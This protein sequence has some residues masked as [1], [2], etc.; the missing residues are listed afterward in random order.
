M[1]VVSGDGE[2]MI[3]GGKSRMVVETSTRIKS[4]GWIFVCTVTFLFTE[5]D[6][7]EIIG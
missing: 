4:L 7:F 1:V 3:D 2:L 6:S 5:N